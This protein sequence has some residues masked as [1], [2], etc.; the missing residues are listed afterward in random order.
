MYGVAAD[1]CASSDMIQRLLC[2]QKV[3]WHD[4]QVAPRGVHRRERATAEARRRGAHN[5]V[6]GPGCVHSQ[7]DARRRNRP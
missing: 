2:A 4:L 3:R 5:G 7:E 1:A 6:A